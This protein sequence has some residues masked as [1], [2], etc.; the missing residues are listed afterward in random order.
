MTTRRTGSIDGRRGTI[1][2]AL[3]DRLSLFASPTFAAM[4]LV[5]GFL[6]DGEPGMLCTTAA[7]SP[8]TG[9][10]AMY[11]LMSAFH[12]APWLRLI[13]EWRGPLRQ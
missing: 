5:T 4:A 1:L 8:L 6:S 3:A 11:A 7:A 12:L 9:M 13:A 2:P 10:A